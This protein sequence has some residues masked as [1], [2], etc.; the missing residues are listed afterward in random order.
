[1]WLS[2]PAQLLCDAW[3][4]LNQTPLSGPLSTHMAWFLCL[5]A[6]LALALLAVHLKLRLSMHGPQE[7]PHLPTLPLIGSLMSLRSPQPPHVLFKGLQGKYGQTYSLKMGSQSVIVVNQHRHAREVL[8]KKG[9]TFA[10]R[11]RTVGIPPL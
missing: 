8:L 1:M 10:G 2:R 4:P 11:P 7:P 6:F 3:S 9:K 5:C